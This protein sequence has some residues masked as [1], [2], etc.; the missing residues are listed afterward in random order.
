MDKYTELIEIGC[1]KEELEDLSRRAAKLGISR[2]KYAGILLFPD[3]NMSK[4]Y[5]FVD[6]SYNQNTKT[7]GFGGFL[8]HDGE[9]EIL[10]G[11]GNDSEMAVMRNVAGEILGSTAAIKKA[12]E[13][14]LEEITIYYDYAGIEMWATGKWKRNKKYTIEYHDFV[15]AAKDSI[16]IRFVKVKGH[17]GIEGN[18]VADKL[19]KESVGLK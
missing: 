13:L 11:S 5:A 8:V 19:A 7:Y 2:T 14:G 4:T 9:K 18:E 3:R 1:T 15:N 17:S 12:L 16:A 6:G 10:Q